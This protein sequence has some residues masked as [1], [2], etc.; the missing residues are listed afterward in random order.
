[1]KRLGSVQ[2][3]SPKVAL[4]ERLDE[5]QSPNRRKLEPEK[6]SLSDAH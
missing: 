5:A 4:E 1:M 3:R 6:N 2:M